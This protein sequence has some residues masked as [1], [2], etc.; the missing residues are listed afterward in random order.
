MDSIR[1]TVQGVYVALSD[2]GASPAV[3]LGLEG[4]RCLPIYIGLWEAISINNA[5]NKEVAP[6]PLTHD[7]FLEFCSRFGIEIQHLFIDTLEDGVYYAHL[8]LTGTDQE[9]TLDCRP[10]DGIALALRCAAN[11]LLSPPV[12]EGSSVRRGDLPNLVDLNTYFQS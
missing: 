2:T 8:H 1:C 10:S 6:R 11:I 3:I 12:A 5:L 4:D 7:L 9:E